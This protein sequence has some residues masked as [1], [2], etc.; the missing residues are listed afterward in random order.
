M[1][2]SELIDRDF[3]ASF[4][5]GVVDDLLVVNFGPEARGAVWVDPSPISDTKTDTV[6]E[7][8]AAL[9][10]NH[11]T[12]DDVAGRIDVEA[13]LEDLDVPVNAV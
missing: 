6:R 13:L 12:T 4:N 2:D 9:L 1:L 10:Y 11:K 8:L 5:T 7:V 3:A